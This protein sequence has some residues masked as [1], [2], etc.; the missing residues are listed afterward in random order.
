M[1]EGEKKMIIECFLDSL[2]YIMA[3]EYFWFAMAITMM[4]GLF[5][6]AILYDGVLENVKK[7]LLSLSVY[8]LLI[9]FMS[10]TRIFP[11]IDTFRNHHPMSGIATVICVSVAYFL[12][13]LIGV[14]ITNKAHRG[15]H[16]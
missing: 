3:D 2:F 1:F 5:I 8:G 7:A 14:F 13:M 12:G 6:G 4:T 15:R 11:I 9:I 10:F 16:L